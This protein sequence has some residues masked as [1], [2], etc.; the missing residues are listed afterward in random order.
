MACSIKRQGT[1]D[2][3]ASATES[4]PFLESGLGHALCWLR[5][6]LLRAAADAA[7]AETDE[8]DEADEADETMRVAADAADEPS[9]EQSEQL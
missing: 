4:D 6:R 1:T 7:D 5:G 9:E 2:S 3:A 8:A